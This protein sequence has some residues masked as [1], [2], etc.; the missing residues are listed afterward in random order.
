MSSQYLNANAPNLDQKIRVYSAVVKQ[1]LV[2]EGEASVVS[3]MSV[4]SSFAA[5][6]IRLSGSGKITL[7]ALVNY[8][9]LTSETTPVTIT[10]NEEQF[11][12]TTAVASNFNPGTTRLFTVTHTGVFDSTMVLLSRGFSA[13]NNQ[14]LLT[15]CAYTETGIIRIGLHNLSTIAATGSEEIIIKL[16]QNV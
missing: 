12:I 2:V 16:I 8:Q 10:G 6:S 11:K 9:Q 5:A 13:G 7:P 4:G 3:K 14:Q 15:W 1:N